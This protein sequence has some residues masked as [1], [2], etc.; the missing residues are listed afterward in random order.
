MYK[1]IVHFRCKLLVTLTHNI[2]LPLIS[3][4]KKPL[5]F[6]FNREEL[7]Q[8][9]DGSLGKDLINMLDK[10][11]LE[12]LPSYEKHDIKHLLLQY[13][14]TEVGEV[15]LQYFMLGN[16]N[17]S[18]AVIVTVAFGFATMPEFWNKF[19]Q[20]YKRGNKSGQLQNW[21]WFSLLHLPTQTL[22]NEINGLKLKKYSSKIFPVNYI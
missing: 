3:Q 14:T 11:Q 19:L 6:P 5:K 21:P 16:R 15:C 4:F 17:Y 2:A 18:F 20:A 12:L 13:D 7:K 22:V 9:P 1:I 8:F 10:K